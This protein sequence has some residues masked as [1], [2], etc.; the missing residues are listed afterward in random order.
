MIVV[1]IVLVN[2]KVQK[3]WLRLVV[4]PGYIALTQ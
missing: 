1:K 4:T 3:N 2:A